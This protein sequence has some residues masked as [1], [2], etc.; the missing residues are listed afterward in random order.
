MDL[1]TKKIYCRSCKK[2]VKSR[3][4][5]EGEITT[6]V[7]NK[8]GSPTYTWDRVSWKYVGG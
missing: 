1:R 3:N 2:L 5:T 7:C 6:I 4:H 8:C